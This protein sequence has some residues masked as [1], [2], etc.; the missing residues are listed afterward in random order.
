MKKLCILVAVTAFATAGCSEPDPFEIDDHCGYEGE[1]GQEKMTLCDVPEEGKED[2]LTGARGLATSVDSG[3][4]AVWEV[5]NQ[6]SDTGTAE[7]RQGGIAW[8]ESSGLTWDEK[9]DRWIQGMVEIDGH[10][11]YYQTFE[12]STPWGRTIQAPL[13]ECA[14]VAIFLRITF[15]SWYGLPFFWPGLPRRGYPPSVPPMGHSK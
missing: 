9:Y 5:R 1:E 8:G 11:T 2:S 10:N 4:T 6:W 7:A 13:L 15:A 12:L 3:D 14:E